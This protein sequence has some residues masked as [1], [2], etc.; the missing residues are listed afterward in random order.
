M[1]PKLS[2]GDGSGSR[3]RHF[4]WD[5]QGEKVDKKETHELIKIIRENITVFSGGY[6]RF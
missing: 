1:D 6:L 3:V 5:K 2:S 4:R